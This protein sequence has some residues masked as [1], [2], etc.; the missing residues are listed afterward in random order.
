MRSL[1]LSPSRPFL[2]FGQ[3][4]TRW[5]HGIFNWQLM[6]SNKFSRERDEIYIVL[7]IFYLTKFSSF[8]KMIDFNLAPVRAIRVSGGRGLEPSV[9]PMFF[10]T[11]DQPNWYQPFEIT[12]PSHERLPT[13]PGFSNVS[14]LSGIGLKNWDSCKYSSMLIDHVKNSYKETIGSFPLWGGEETTVISDYHST[15]LGD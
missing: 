7:P 1:A 6:I 15:G 13:L 4:V 8:H 5:S 3:R 11:S 14:P 9:T 10:A 12:H 2:G